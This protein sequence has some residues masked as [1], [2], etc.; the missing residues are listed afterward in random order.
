MMIKKSKR[1]IGGGFAVLGVLA[2]A[3]FLYSVTGCQN[4]EHASASKKIVITGPISDVCEDEP[5]IQDLV[6]EKPK[7]KTDVTEDCPQ[8]CVDIDIAGEELPQSKSGKFKSKDFQ[9]V[10][11]VRSQSTGSVSS[12]SKLGFRILPR[13]RKKAVADAGGIECCRIESSP[14]PASKC[15]NR[16]CIEPSEICPQE[17]PP[18]EAKQ[19]GPS[20]EDYQTITDNPFYRVTDEP[21]STFSIDVDT[22]S[23]ANMRRYLQSGQMPPKDAV[24][25][26]EMINYFNYD[27][28]PP[29]DNHPFAVHVD[30]A[31]AP[32]RPEHML[33]RIAL[34]GQTVHPK[35]RPAM[36][37]VFLLDVSGSMSD[38]NKLPYVKQGLKLLV[39][40][41][42][43][44]DR[45][46]IVVY[47]G[48]SGIVLPSTAGSDKHKILESLDRLEAGGS[49]NGG[50]G[51]NLAYATAAGNFIEKGVNRVILC[52][53]GDFNVGVT[54]RGDLER[55]IEHKAKTGI[56][57]SVLGFGMGNYK[58]STLEQLSGKGNG[59]YAYIDTINEA[60]K[61]L[62]E[63]MSGTLITIAKD[64]KIQVEFNPAAV[65]GYRLIGYENRKLRKEDFNNDKVDAGDIGA[66]HTVTALYEV[67]PVG[68]SVD[69][70]GGVDELKYQ[71]PAATTVTENGRNAEELLT[72]KLRYK[73]PEKETS[74][75]VTCPYKRDDVKA[76]VHDVGNDFAW[77]ASVSGF[78]M[79]L[80]QSPHKGSL[81]LEEVLSLARLSE[82]DDSHGYR[83][84]FIA[85]VRSAMGLQ[86]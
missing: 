60:K 47:A 31:A 68:L 45:V 38:S 64:V 15:D 67:I 9:A 86:N 24:R 79:V 41:L 36:N 18:K 21:L 75:L 48:A 16:S 54:N 83:K 4:V 43:G 80:R 7:S 14:C 2:V 10:L 44:N 70:V 30:A 85:L 76:T 27:Y 34:K 72:V 26:E 42:N 81:T 5:I 25:I 39:N 51:I 33:V 3:G 11:G 57:L 50:A 55:I 46:A 28:A 63:Q 20:L 8:L 35:E 58:D 53:D 32:W 84:E 22:A 40:Q 56:Y 78:G 49:T 6:L 71:K 62:V 82:G 73:L 13:N 66:G 69:G 23:Y 74:N 77:A 59:N 37:L 61:V 17:N 12:E 52:T 65:A 1:V 19:W 29:T